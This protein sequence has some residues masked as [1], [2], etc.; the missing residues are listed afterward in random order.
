MNPDTPRDLIINPSLTRTANELLISA[1]IDTTALVVW[2]PMGVSTP[3]PNQNGCSAAYRSLNELLAALATKDPASDGTIWIGKNYDSATMAD[4][5]ILL[6]GATLARMAQHA[7]RIQG[8]W[9]G[10]GT[11]TVD[12][13]SPSR[14]NG[15]SLLILNWTG[16]VALRN[17]QGKNG[18]GGHDKVSICVRTAGNIELDRVLASHS[19]YG[20]TL[21]NA[22][23]ISARPVSITVTNCD[24]SGND[25]AGLTIYSNGPVT[26]QH[27]TASGNLLGYGVTVLNEND[28]SSSP[29]TVVD[30]KFIRN[31]SVGLTIRSHG[32]VSL[33][34][35]LAQD[36]GGEGVSAHNQDGDV[37]LRRV[38]M[39]LENGS[40]GLEVESNGIITAYGLTAVANGGNGFSLRT[41]VPTDASGQAV[42]LQEVIADRNGQTGLEIYSDGQV[43]LTCSSTCQ[44]ANFGLR[45]RGATNANGPTG[46]VKLEGFISERN[47]TNEDILTNTPVM[48]LPVDIAAISGQ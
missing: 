16:H 19:L 23:S 21:D 6:N 45:V 29:V 34:D 42:T 28:F 44:N 25:Y 38:N 31:K 8:G 48:R 30:G 40:H 7:L 10:I 24:F 2:C 35:V 39:F 4:K 13:D 18:I 26:L 5:T 11:E 22:A 20:A 27:V 12:M 33:T 43:G 32:A 3:T 9:N 47:R 15:A 14:L 37:L 36:N 17:L 41:T 46:A 1:Q